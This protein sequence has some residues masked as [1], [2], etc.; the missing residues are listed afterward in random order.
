MKKVLSLLL[1]IVM[2]VG[3]TA[4]NDLLTFASDMYEQESNDKQMY[5]N[6]IKINSKVYGSCGQG[7]TDYFCFE[8][9]SRKRIAIDFTHEYT[10][11]GAWKIFIRKVN[12]S[13]G[14]TNCGINYGDDTSTYIVFDEYLENE[15]VYIK[16]ETYEYYGYADIDK[17][18]D[19]S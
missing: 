19:Y 1:S 10:D 11:S 16:I 9:S 17:A 8:V 4:N 12:K 14:Y 6:S 5:A 3:F 2:I 15:K 13:S 18:S 7:D